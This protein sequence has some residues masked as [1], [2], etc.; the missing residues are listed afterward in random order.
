MQK[1][2]QSRNYQKRSLRAAQSNS[3]QSYTITG[4]PENSP[5][6][7]KPQQYATIGTT[8]RSSVAM[9][10]PP[11]TESVLAAQK[12]RYPM[13]K[14]FD[15]VAIF[16]YHY[17]LWSL[18]LTAD[19][20][21]EFFLVTYGDIPR[22]INS[23]TY[24]GVPFEYY[25]KRVIRDRARYYQMRSL[26]KEDRLTIVHT[27]YMKDTYDVDSWGEEMVDSVLDQ[28][29]MYTPTDSSKRALDLNKDDQIPHSRNRIRQALLQLT[30]MAADDISPK[31]L[32]KLLHMC[33]CPLDKFFQW[34]RALRKLK[35]EKRA[36]LQSQ[37][38]I[39]NKHYIHLLEYQTLLQC[40][41]SPEKQDAL[42]EKIVRCERLLKAS[43][44]MVR[45]YSTAPTQKD[46]A[47]VLG[48]P[49]GTVSS[50][51][52]TGKKLLAKALEEERSGQVASEEVCSEAATS[53]K[54]TFRGSKDLK[55]LDLHP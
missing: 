54:S 1:I 22:I 30:L 24:H 50:Q 27:S 48:I 9:V 41:V 40:S 15:E 46:I 37:I 19:E 44:E 29:T 35:D 38:C 7:K 2:H 45:S 28:T 6:P 52:A 14:L 18:H 8:Y 32:T 23:F 34:N 20:N 43:Q 42:K 12:G 53:Q 11:L 25:L 4:Q 21:S 31:Q 13:E 55:A 3:S 36:R 16:I 26:H 51:M 47:H 49:M 5:Q 33:G 17:P 39:R 10:P